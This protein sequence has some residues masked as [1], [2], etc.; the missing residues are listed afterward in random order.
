M[1]FDFP[2]KIELSIPIE[3]DADGYIDKECP[4]EN[5]LLQFKVNEDDWEAIDDESNI[6][7]PF[8]RH[9]ADTGSWWTTEQLEH[10]EQ[11]ALKKVEHMIMGALDSALG[12]MTKNFNRSQKNNTFIQMTMSY[13][14]DKSPEPI[15]IPASA[16]EIMRS[17]VKCEKC[18]FRY[19]YIGTAHFCPSCGFCDV[20][21]IFSLHIEKMKKMPE[22][23][24]KIRD[25]L[26]REESAVMVN[27]LVEDAIKSSVTQF[28]KI[29][30]HLYKSATGIEQ[31][32]GKGNIFQRLN[33]ASSEWKKISD[34]DFLCFIN[35]DEFDRLNLFFQ[36]RHVLGH[37]DGHIDDKYVINSG[38]NSYKPAQRLIVKENDVVEFASLLEKLV[39]GMRKS[40]PH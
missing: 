12:E 22:T 40:L 34:N 9:E 33:D 27:T 2:E 39:N 38:D 32:Q 7:C 13:K 20:E 26:D 10:A 19:A 35:Q 11:M 29:S 23:L 4:N 31:P 24:G 1:S 15:M 25:A 30:R 8:C 18:G 3:A 17:K 21:S 16:A 36:R 28:E 6:Y 37:N 14:P 5:C